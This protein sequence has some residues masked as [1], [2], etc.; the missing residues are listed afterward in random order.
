MFIILALMGIILLLIYF[1]FR[2]VMK[3]EKEKP[4][5]PANINIGILTKQL[6]QYQT[7]GGT[8]KENIVVSPQIGGT[9]KSFK[10]QIQNDK[11]S[12]TSSSPRPKK[13][14]L[15]SPV[16]VGKDGRA[17]NKRGVLQKLNDFNSDYEYVDVPKKMNRFTS[18]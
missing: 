14:D 4:M 6:I 7:Q 11:G 18:V 15:G 13:D 9:T 17:K 3:K 12:S 5:T 8:P 2:L 1:L 16:E 10:P